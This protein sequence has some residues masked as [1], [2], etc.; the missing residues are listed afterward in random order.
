MLN[1]AAFLFHD[2]DDDDGS[3]TSLLQQDEDQTRQHLQDL[4][5]DHGGRCE[6][7]VAWQRA[8]VSDAEDERC[9][10][11]HQHGQADVL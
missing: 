7:A 5:H 11:D 6:E 3:L 4:R 2:D 10:L 1:C 9:I 8:D